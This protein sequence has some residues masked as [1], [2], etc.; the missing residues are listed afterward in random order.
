[1]APTTQYGPRVLGEK[2][3]KKQTLEAEKGGRIYGER[4][5]GKRITGES[6]P[7]AEAG[8][9]DAY[10]TNADV[11]AALEGA[12]DAKVDEILAAEAG[13]ESGPRKG[14]LRAILQHEQQ[15]EGGA[16]EDVVEKL[17]TLIG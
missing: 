16:R 8:T 6:E 12:D 11:E 17:A 15:R 2:K 14:A 1:M 10:A 5:L 3:F 9:E 7:A 13:R 4:V